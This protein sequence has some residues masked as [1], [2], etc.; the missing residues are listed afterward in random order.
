MYQWAWHYLGLWS[1]PVQPRHPRYTVYSV[2]I[3]F[4]PLIVFNG[5]L[6]LSM[7]VSESLDDVIET[8]LIA[9]STVMTTVKVLVFITSRRYVS[10]L[11]YV[12]KLLET[13]YAISPHERSILLGAKRKSALARIVFFYCTFSV[14]AI[15][16]L[17]TFTQPKRSLIWSSLYPFDWRSNIAW[18]GLAMIFQVACTSYILII[19]ISVDMW[20]VAAF[21]MLNGFLDVLCGRM[22]RLGKSIKCNLKKTRI[23]SVNIKQNRFH[24]KQLIDCVKYHLLCIRYIRTL[25]VYNIHISFFGTCMVFVPSFFSRI[26]NFEDL[27]MLRNSINFKHLFPFYRYCRILENASKLHYFLQLAVSTVMI[28]TTVYLLTTVEFFNFKKKTELK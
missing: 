18:Y 25:H 23:A 3:N 20:R 6:L 15:L 27:G 8:L 4:T 28:G 19:I 9:S 11:I 7:L 24:E 10:Q 26:Y 22:Q 2:L 1:I 21:L 5:C 13:F 17:N 12:M 14:L 16:I